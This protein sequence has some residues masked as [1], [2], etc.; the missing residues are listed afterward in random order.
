MVKSPVKPPAHA[1]TSVISILNCSRD[2]LKDLPSLLVIADFFVTLPFE[3]ARNKDLKVKPVE[4]KLAT[5]KRLCAPLVYK[6][7]RSIRKDKKQDK[8]EIWLKNNKNYIKHI[9]HQMYKFTQTYY[10]LARLSPRVSTV[11]SSHRPDAH[12]TT[13]GGVWTLGTTWS[14]VHLRAAS[15]WGIKWRYRGQNAPRSS[16]FQ[17]TNYKS[18]FLQP[19]TA[20]YLYSTLPLAEKWDIAKGRAQRRVKPVKVR[21][22]ATSTPIMWIRKRSARF[23]TNS[24][25]QILQLKY[26]N[27]AYNIKVKEKTSCSNPR[28]TKNSSL[29]VW[30]KKVLYSQ[31]TCEDSTNR[32][33]SPG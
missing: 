22:Q 14:R 33:R 28:T 10:L 11:G 13:G 24:C 21:A 19:N 29:E 7:W 3:V 16:F 4:Q 31:D 15:G 2:V 18:T 25:V 20:G 5:K 23:R 30:P 26:L 27:P 1:I 8:W 17:T 12:M 9:K 32:S 6:H